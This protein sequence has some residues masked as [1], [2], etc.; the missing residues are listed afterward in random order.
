MKFIEDIN[1]DNKK[2]ILRLDLNVT[3]NDNKIE[4]DTK[5]K[6]SLKTIN[7]ILDHKCHVLIMSHLGK[8]KTK[9]DEEKNSLRI[10]G[11]SLSDLLNKK[12]NFIPFT[13]GKELEESFINNEITL[14][15]NTRFEDLDSKKESSCDEELA[16]YWA[17]LG[18]IF[19]ND[20]FG[21][22]HRRH[23]SNYGI[24]KHL[25]SAYGYLIQKE[26]IGLNPIINEINRPLTIIMGG[27]KVDDK[28][29][30]IK[31]I[32]VK[33]DYL[34]VGGGIANTFLC[35]QGYN[36]GKSLYSKEYVDEIKKIIKQYKDKI[37]IP[38]DVVV[39]PDNT[40]IKNITDVNDNDNICDV[41]PKTIN[42]YNQVLS[43]SH[44]MFL[45][46][47]VGIYEKDDCSTG[48]K[49]LLE[50]ISNKDIVKIAGGG[51][52]LA[53]INKFQYE[54]RFNY[55]ST[56]GGATLSYIANGYLECFEDKL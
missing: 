14:M 47:A 12:V 38:I 21:T 32:I 50:V 19:V 55:L 51:D 26:I 54:N 31:K 49:A 22:T 11:D 18:D 34:I 6:E 44:T 2:V 40:T 33:T 39:N 29:A 5:I 8:I 41:G 43:K 23:A 52:A 42:L 46:G 53:S 45:N 27:A 13:R 9:E 24:A 56:G 1:I 4:D 7:Y 16:A 36:V 48:T 10:V 35:A 20:A 17:S 28:I 15:E 37:I 25:E 30:L 3:I